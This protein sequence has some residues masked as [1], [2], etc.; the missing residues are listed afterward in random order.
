VYCEGCGDQSEGKIKEETAQ[1]EEVQDFQQQE[2][3]R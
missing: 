3:I 2:E 1:Q